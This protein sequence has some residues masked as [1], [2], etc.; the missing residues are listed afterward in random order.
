MSLKTSG[1]IFFNFPIRYA[2]SS[3]RFDI[4]FIPQPPPS[5][6]VKRIFLKKLS[7]TVCRN[8]CHITC[9]LNTLN[10]VQVAITRWPE[11][12]FIDHSKKS[13]TFS[14]KTFFSRFTDFFFQRLSSRTIQLNR[15]HGGESGSCTRLQG[16][17]VHVITSDPLSSYVASCLM[18][19]PSAPDCFMRWYYN[20]YATLTR[21]IYFIFI[22]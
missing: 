6:A 10:T 13:D 5:P 9:D 17:R 14:I 11:F 2:T 21:R 19:H 4:P 18:R 15:K 7:I 3:T 12:N 22:Y 16:F 20:M 8:L 1:T